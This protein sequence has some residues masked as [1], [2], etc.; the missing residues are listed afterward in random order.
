MTL[1]FFSPA[2]KE[3]VSK[4]RYYVSQFDGDS[5]QIIDAVENREVCVCSNYDD[6]EDAEERVKNI[7]RLL[8]ESNKE[9]LG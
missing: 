1:V 4:E 5:Y 8:N 6:R 7:V 2:K 9:T 3:H